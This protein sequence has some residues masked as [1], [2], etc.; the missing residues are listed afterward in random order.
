MEI[1]SKVCFPWDEQIDDLA[2]LPGYF[3]MS[4][5]LAPCSEQ[6]SQRDGKAKSGEQSQGWGWHLQGRI[7]SAKPTSNSSRSQE[8]PPVDSLCS[9]PWSEHSPGINM[10]STLQHLLLCPKVQ[11]EQPAQGN[12]VPARTL[13]SSKFPSLQALCNARLSP[14]PPPH[15]GAAHQGKEILP[16]LPT[17]PCSAP[18]CHVKAGRHKPPP[19]SS[20]LAWSCH[21]G[22]SQP[23]PEKL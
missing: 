22:S 21:T 16:Q 18:L 14:W 23:P 1:L 5:P 20:A 12:G 8:P 17:I 15:R 6:L 4:L 7:V 3:S 2:R 19:A 9:D 10:H 13:L 11:K